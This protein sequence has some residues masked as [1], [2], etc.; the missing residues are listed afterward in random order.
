MFQYSDPAGRG[1]RARLPL[2][3]FEAAAA[4]LG[5]MAPWAGF[6]FS[7]AALV[8]ATILASCAGPSA[9]NGFVGTERCATCHEQEARYCAYGAHRTVRCERCHG[10]GARHAQPDIEPRPAMSLGGPDLCMAC[11]AARIGSFEDHLR[12]LER[13]HKVTLDRDKSGK[14]CVYCHDPHL[15][16]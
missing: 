13:V 10:P 14:D 9:G 4:I 7:I 15:L 12:R 3:R 1:R 16:E 11:H 5:V 2:C 8:L 6:F